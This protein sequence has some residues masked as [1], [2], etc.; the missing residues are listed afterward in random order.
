MPVFDCTGRLLAH[1]IKHVHF[2][3]LS[4]FLAWKVMHIVLVYFITL[5]IPFTPKLFSPVISGSKQFSDQS[6][7]PN[8]TIFFH[9]E[10]ETSQIWIRNSETS[11][12]FTSFTQFRQLHSDRMVRGNISFRH[13]F[14]LS[15]VGCSH[16]IF[17]LNTSCISL[18]NWYNSILE[19]WILLRFKLLQV[20]V[21]NAQRTLRD[22][23]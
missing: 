20:S 8:N 12:S 21:P 22:F 17:V 4:M 14:F 2:I 9:E 1:R 15:E 3:C 11:S 18:I 19:C 5:Q 23:E 10:K 16:K 6:F 7:K 13:C